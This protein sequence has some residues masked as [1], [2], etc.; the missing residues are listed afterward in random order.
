MGDSIKE[1]YIG[2]EDIGYTQNDIDEMDITYHL[3]KLGYRKKQNEKGDNN[4]QKTK[5]KNE[6]NDTEF[7]TFD[8]VSQNI[9]STT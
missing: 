9:D 2:L 8:V 1:L 5:A 3:E 7:L 6:I 4:K